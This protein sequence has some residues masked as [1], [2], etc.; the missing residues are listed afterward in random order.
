MIDLDFRFEG[1]EHFERAYDDDMIVSIV[2]EYLSVLD[3]YVEIENDVKI[4]VMERP[5]PRFDKKSGYVKDG[6]HIVIPDIVTCPGV[7]FL[8]RNDSLQAIYSIIKD[9][10]NVSSIGDVFDE[11][12]ICKNN[13]LMY[14][15]SK[16]G[17]EP[18]KVSFILK[19]NKDTTCF[20]HRIVD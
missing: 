4:Y 20:S 8:A 15:S 18:Y 7:Q 16:P 6:V 5:G 1:N 3:K 19:R 17:T 12:V 9:I 11:S 14:G 13:W 10:G 2:S